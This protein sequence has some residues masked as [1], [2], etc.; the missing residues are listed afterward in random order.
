MWTY[1]L[2]GILGDSRNAAGGQKW[3]E[4]K[5]GRQDEQNDEFTEA[6]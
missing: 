4:A 2:L 6:G 1:S 5:A 3:Q